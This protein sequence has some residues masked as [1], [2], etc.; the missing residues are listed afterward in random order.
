MSARFWAIATLVTG[1]ISLGLFVVFAMLPEMRAAA[2]CLPAGSVVQFELARDVDQLRAIFGAPDS[3]CRPLAIAAMDAV[4]HIDLIAFIPAY[5]AFCM[6]AALFLSG[7][8][9]RPLTI[10]AV[11]SALFAAAGD[12]LETTTLLDISQRL[13]TPGDLLSLSQLGAWSK[14]ALLAAH[15]VFCAGLCFVAEKRRP[16]LGALLSLP[17]PGVAAAAFN[18]VTLAN[19]MNGAFAIAW[20]ALLVVAGFSAARAKGAQA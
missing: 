13:D 2:S 1:L 5:T 20:I 17:A 7:G 19:A 11:A 15:A 18:H 9:W 14:F 10:A 12:L 3:Q 4:N 8:A 6:C 16:I